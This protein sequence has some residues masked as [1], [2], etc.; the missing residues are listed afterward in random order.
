[1]SYLIDNFPVCES[2]WMNNMKYLLPSMSPKHVDILGRRI[3][4][5]PTWSS[6]LL[7]DMDL[8]DKRNL[9]MSVS[10]A[11][12]QNMVDRSRKRKADAESCTLKASSL[13]VLKMLVQQPELWIG[14]T[15]RAVKD[16][17]VWLRKAA[18]SLRSMMKVEEKAENDGSH[19]DILGS[20]HLID[21]LPLEYAT[22]T[23]HSVLMMGL[24]ALLL[25]LD[26]AD[27]VNK[28][29]LWIMLVR[30][31]DNAE[32]LSSLFDY[33]PS[34]EF[35]TWTLDSTKGLQRCTEIFTSVFDE[36]LRSP[37]GIKDVAKWVDGP[38]GSHFDAHFDVMVV[39]MEKL[40]QHSSAV[41]NEEKKRLSMDMFVSLRSKFLERLE[42]GLQLDG[43]VHVLKGALSLIDMHLK[44]LADQVRWIF[45]LHFF[46]I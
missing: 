38:H 17:V 44:E 26:V 6:T 43:G 2:L 21:K 7:D 1:M 41:V 9:Q 4:A 5:S 8:V 15:D 37:K 22:G 14:S 13:N 28:E 36:V 18:E 12:F 3:V 24:L 39:A 11:V 25:S 40:S 35:L 30:L 42:S 27:V 32:K 20:L 31:L 46:P 45:S 23:V 10:L 34:E 16:V 33:I 19:C 29:R